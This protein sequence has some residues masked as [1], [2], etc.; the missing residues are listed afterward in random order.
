MIENFYICRQ[1]KVRSSNQDRAGCFSIDNW[2]LGFVADGMGGHYGGGQAS[3][4]VAQACA[5]W[6]NSFVASPQRPGFLQSQEQLRGLL[7][8]CHEE[9]AK[10]APPQTVCGTT[11]VLLWIAGSEYA[12][13]SVG[14]SRC[15]IVTRRL[16]FS[17]RPIQL[18]HDDVSTE[19]HL[20]GKLTRALG[21]GTCSLSLRTG[22]I[23]PKT[24]FALCSD[25]IY[26]ACPE[27]FGELKKITPQRS[28]MDT[29]DK[30]AA[31]VD[32]NGAPDNYSLVLLRI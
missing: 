11:A 22:T 28:L 18:T 26:K 24:V 7:H 23:H 32:A 6:W 29:A 4:I 17:Q 20:A 15:Y 19:P 25:G 3:E 30:I 16:G 9:I 13:F 5:R 14:D 21:P 27:F 1:G 12:L 2:C 31:Q 8:H 10:I